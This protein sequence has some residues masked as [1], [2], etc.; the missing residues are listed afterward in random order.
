MEHERQIWVL[1][2][3]LVEHLRTIPED[4]HAWATEQFIK[5]AV[6][7]LEGS[8]DLDG[9]TDSRVNNAVRRLWE[10]QSDELSLRARLEYWFDDVPRNDSIDE[11]LERFVHL[12]VQ[13]NFSPSGI[14]NL[15]FVGFGG[16]ELFANHAP[17]KIGGSVGRDLFSFTSPSSAVNDTWPHQ[18]TR[19]SAQFDA[20]EE[21]LLGYSDSLID[22]A[23]SRLSLPEPDN[24]ESNQSDEA[25]LLTGRSLTETFLREVG[26]AAEEKRMTPFYQA[27]SSLPLLTL[28]E[29][30][31]TLVGLQALKNLIQAETPS[32]SKSAETALIT[33]ADGFRWI[34]HLT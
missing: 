22:T 13:K 29:T 27:V 11:L 19:F 2:R 33:R 32:V 34:E 15:A 3:T 17:V 7:D 30:A 5:S 25:G 8:R 10:F 16:D 28:A 14:A 21:F 24:L 9:H 20:I 18:L 26:A 31:K 1:H 23:G 12:Q 6:L 4:Q